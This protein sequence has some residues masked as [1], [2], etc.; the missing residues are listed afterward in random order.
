MQII[1][2]EIMKKEITKEYKAND[3]KI[4]NNEEECRK[5]EN[6]AYAVI[7]AEFRTT[8]LKIITEYDLLGYGIGSEDYEIAIINIKN[9]NDLDKVNRMIEIT[10]EN[11]IVIII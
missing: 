7:N 4:F 11:I 2:K 8:I 6:T 9:H 5:Y 1:E 10:N 3:G